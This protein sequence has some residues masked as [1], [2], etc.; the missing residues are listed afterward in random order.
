VV[1]LAVRAL[2][3]AS[4]MVAVLDTIWPRLV[5]APGVEA[6]WWFASL[7]LLPAVIVVEIVWLRGGRLELRAV[8]ADASLVGAWCVGV[9]AVFLRSWN[10]YAIV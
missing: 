1:H 5:L 2:V 8:R 3:I 7:I 4:V 9:V 6:H 10:H